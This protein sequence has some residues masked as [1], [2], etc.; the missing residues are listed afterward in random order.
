MINPEAWKI[1]DGK[2]FLA[3]SKGLSDKWSESPAA[4]I[5][6]ADENWEKIVGQN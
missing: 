2:L 4:N 6:K 1:V 3:L 5:A